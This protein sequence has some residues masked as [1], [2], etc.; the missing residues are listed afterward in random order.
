MEAMALPE[1]ISRCRAAYDQLVAETG[2]VP[3]SDEVAR[4]AGIAKN[5]VK[6]AWEDI[7][8]VPGVDFYVSRDI[9]GIRKCLCCARNFPSSHIGNRLCEACKGTTLF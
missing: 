3:R 7:T 1:T 6:L 9:P 2:K 5:A 4:A 8:G